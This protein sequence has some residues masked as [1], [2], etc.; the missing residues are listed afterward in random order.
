MITGLR[1]ALILILALIA[2]PFVFAQTDNNTDPLVRLLQAK[3]VLTEAEVRSVTANGSSVQ[4][5]DRLPAPLRGKSGISA[6]EF[7][8]VRLNDSAPAVKTIT[9]DYKTAATTPSAVPQ[10][11]PPKVIAAI[12]PTRLLGI[13]VPK[14]EG[15]IPDIKFGAGARLKP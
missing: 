7:E 6:A 1:L 14:R 4:Q 11:T 5:R 15:L 2:S 12:A 3:G 13:D 10:P 8:A 9:A